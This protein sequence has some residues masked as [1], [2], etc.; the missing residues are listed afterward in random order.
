MEATPK[1]ATHPMILIAAASVTAVSLAGVAHL[2]GWMPGKTP[3]AEQPAL[4]AAA[5]AATAPVTAPVAAALPAPAPVA[6][7]APVAK[8]EPAP[9]PR[10]VAKPLPAK[11][12]AAPAPVPHEETAQ[13]NEGVTNRIG[14]HGATEVTQA[15][16]APPVCKECGSV[17]SIREVTVQGEATPLGAIAG[18]VIGGLLGNQVGNGRGKQ[19]ATIAGAIGGAYAGR[20]VEKNTR[21]NHQYEISV[22]FDD[23]T[24]RTFTQAQMPSLQNG[25]RVKLVNGGLNRL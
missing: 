19:L 18:G 23:G 5:P 16:V 22:R 17:E 4:V 13:G 3:V 15:P 20:E 25:D 12:K 6:S 2:A 1:P 10:P 14:G 9:A 7:P 8:A 24:T 11:P 21:T